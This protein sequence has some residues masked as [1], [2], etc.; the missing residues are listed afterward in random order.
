VE[1]AEQHVNSWLRP[2]G[3]HP[4][5]GGNARERGNWRRPAAP[6]ETPLPPDTIRLYHYT[7]GPEELASITKHGL[8]VSKAKGHTY[9]EPNM[10]WASAE[11]P[12]YDRHFVEI[13]ASPRQL[14]IGSGYFK[15]RDH[16]T[17]KEIEEITKRGSNVTFHGDVRPDQIIATHTPSDEA[18]RYIDDSPYN[19]KELRADPHA[20]DFDPATNEAVRRWLAD[21]PGGEAR[22]RGRWRIEPGTPEAKAVAEW[23]TTDDIYSAGWILP[24]GRMIDFHRRNDSD[25][26]DHAETSAVLGDTLDPYRAAM[27]RGWVRVIPEAKYRHIGIQAAKPPTPAQRARILAQTDDVHEMFV[28]EKVLLPGNNWAGWST[29]V[30]LATPVS[31]RRALDELGE[32]TAYQAGEH[33]TRG[34]WR[35]EPGTPEARAVDQYGTTDDILQAGWL[36]PDGTLVD[37]KRKGRWDPKRGWKEHEEVAT[38]AFVDEP[39]FEESW[40]TTRSAAHGDPTGFAELNGWVRVMPSHLMG[41]RQWV[42]F[43]I[44]KPMTEAQVRVARRGADEADEVAVSVRNPRGGD[45]WSSGVLPGDRLQL[46]QAIRTANR[47]AEMVPAGAARTRGRWRTEGTYDGVTLSQMAKQRWRDVG[48][49][50]NSKG[51]LLPDG[52]VVGWRGNSEHAAEAY[53]LDHERHFSLPD[54]QRG[55]LARWV[56]TNYGKGRADYVWVDTKTPL[57]DQQQHVLHE[58]VKEP[59]TELILDGPGNVMSGMVPITSPIRLGQV[60]RS[61][62]QDAAGG[63]RRLRAARPTAT[64]T[65]RR[66]RAA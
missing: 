45:F 27:R 32:E 35:V 64:P 66:R 42:S 18:Y 1:G 17:A 6:G 39:G 36:L 40:S 20:Y 57:T 34:Q 59:G 33:R 54:L 24:D 50:A 52:T 38:A 46:A 31:V 60:I 61:I 10:V 13:A 5:L 49:D 62:N 19:Q 48:P 3:N 4:R 21:H 8:L 55:G 12:H 16:P 2:L 41:G 51:F 9:G 15:D 30:P 37:M 63:E 65:P 7:E 53:D 14:D 26:V 58:V 28:E 47:E 23:G 43:E 25:Y 11:T 22:T 29:R 56:R 44:R